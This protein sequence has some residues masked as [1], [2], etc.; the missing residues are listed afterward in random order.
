MRCSARVLIDRDRS[1]QRVLT[2]AKLGD[3]MSA[4]RKGDIG[5]I[6][7]QRP[8]SKARA[9]NSRRHFG[10]DPFAGHCRAERAPSIT[11]NS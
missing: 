2:A 10:E 3:D 1:A 8:P 5:G 6:E 4:V 7:E 11:R 9:S